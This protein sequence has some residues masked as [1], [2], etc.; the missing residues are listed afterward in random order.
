MARKRVIEA[1]YALESFAEESIFEN[2]QVKAHSW[3][4]TLSLVEQSRR[5][6]LSDSETFKTLKNPR[7]LNAQALL[8]Y[9][10]N[11]NRFFRCFRREILGQ[12]EKGPISPDRRVGL[13][14]RSSSW[15]CCISG[16]NVK[17][18]RGDER[19]GGWGEKI[20]HT[21]VDS[22]LNYKSLRASC[23]RLRQSERHSRGTGWCLGCAYFLRLPSGLHCWAEYHR[24]PLRTPS[25]S[26]Y[27]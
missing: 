4:S 13:L 21:G 7:W 24:R 23:L 25:P 22:L 27:P 2:I 17:N 16:R 15:N 10:C 20:E 3:R 6:S 26:C 5:K 9:N 14:G 18:R 1:R 12:R 11:A 8:L 19:K